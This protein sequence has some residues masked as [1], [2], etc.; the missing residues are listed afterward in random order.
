MTNTKAKSQRTRAKGSVNKQSKFS[1]KQMFKPIKTCDSQNTINKK[2]Q[3]V[4]T[5]K[6]K[7]KPVSPS[8]SNTNTQKNSD[9]LE[10]SIIKRNLFGIRLNHDQLNRDLKEMWKEQVERQK[11]QWN[12]DFEKLKP[13][14]RV[15]PR[16]C[17]SLDD[18]AHSSFNRY[19][20]IKVNTY[21][22]PSINNPGVQS[23]SLPTHLLD[24]SMSPPDMAISA[25][26]KAEIDYEHSYHNS[27]ENIEDS[28]ERDSEGEDDE[29]EYDEAL[30]VPQFYKY[31]RRLK[32]HEEN[33]R[34]QAFSGLRQGKQE[35]KQKQIKN[36]VKVSNSNK[37][38]KTKRL[39]PAQKLLTQNLIITFSENRKD[40]LR[41]A[42]N[43]SPLNKP[44]DSPPKKTK[45]NLKQQS[46]LGKF[47]LNLRWLRN[48]G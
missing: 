6:P 11:L 22:A 30:A 28:Y 39:N 15:S 48:Y 14:N 46:L 37:N 8:I 38:L 26:D 19:D 41:S 17:K 1:V 10:R 27:H 43:V 32:L 7:L 44:S 20:W 29:E 40:T 34:S 42:Q 31:Q 47:V 4:S 36:N 3:K 21:Y 35:M 24:S 12:F 2:L 25:F 16:S 18:I 13:V 23:I 45:D 5:P 9:S 33:T